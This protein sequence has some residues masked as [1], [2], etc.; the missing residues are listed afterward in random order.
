MN[1]SSANLIQLIHDR[2][3]SLLEKGELEEALHTV[4][5]AVDKSQQEL[6]SEMDTID[7]FV[8]SLQKRAEIYLQIGEYQEAI[9]DIQQALDQLD[10]RSDRLGEIGTLYALLGAIYSNQGEK[11]AMLQAWSTAIEFFQKHEPPLLLDIAFIS[12][13]IGC[14]YRAE[15]D[16]DKAEDYLLK[17]LEIW[18]TELGEKNEETASVSN[19][20]GAVYFASGHY[21]Q[22]RVMHS[23]ALDARREIFG[24]K[25]PD[26]AQ[27]HN[28]LALAFFKAGDSAW[29][30][31]HF[32]KALA[33]FESLGVCY[34][35]NLEEV[36]S[37]YCEFLRMEGEDGLA[38]AIAGRVQEFLAGVL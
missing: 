14:A 9:D 19:N 34:A 3:H 20:L 33:I 26:T 35:T 32:E 13:N 25:H 36:S 10:N 12:N 38:N 5:A 29:A 2:A 18:H 28:N 6:S 1:H 23:M 37:N 27:S 11:E 21:E 4:N 31:L 30:K 16:L 24:E 7:S 15:G 17:S 8:N 22:S